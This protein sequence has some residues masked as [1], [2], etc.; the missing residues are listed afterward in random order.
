MAHSLS[1]HLLRLDGN[2]YKAYRQIKGTHT[3]NRFKLTISHVQADPF[4]AP[5][6]VS[7]KV[8]ADVA[9]LPAAWLRGQRQ[10]ALADYLNRQLYRQAQKLQ[11]DQGAG[12][13]GTLSVLQPSQAILPRSSVQVSEDGVEARLGVGLPAFGRRIA[14]QLAA[15][16]L[17]ET[18]PALVEASLLRTALAERE[19]ERHLDAYED[20]IA[21]RQ[22]LPEH[23]LVGFVANGAILPRRSG[24]EATPLTDGAMPFQSP[25][26]LEVTLQPPH[27]GAVTGMGIPEGVTLIVGGGYHGKSTLLRALAA[28]IYNHIPGDGREQVVCDATAVKIRAEEGRSV[29][30]VNISPFIGA[31][32]QGIST[33]AFS[34]TNASGSTSQATNIIEALE[35][36]ARVLLV[37]EDTAATNFMIRDRTMQALISKEKEPITPFVDK[38]RQLYN[39]YGVSTVLVMGGSGDYFGVADTVIALDNYRPED[40]TIAA[41][42]LAK[43][44]G[45]RQVEGGQRF[46]TLSQRQLRLPAFDSGRRSRPKV[47]V[48][49]V[50]SLEIDRQPIDLRAVAQLVEIG[51][52]RAIAAALVYSQQQGLDQQPLSDWLE[53]I[54]QQMAL[55]GLD[56]LDEWSRGDL[57]AFRPQELAAVINRVRTLHLG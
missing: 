57:T 2:S 45:P 13:S 31:L 8:P 28:G 53:A 1:N 16:L 51:Q 10:T 23:S 32:P 29:C 36:G 27:A 46:G 33:A 3:F 41:Q 14:G 47:K 26:S 9:G 35:A 37:D 20:A 15:K 42:A 30:G 50:D 55:E 22:Q 39:D 6:R 40:V 49:D 44:A 54:N 7:L 48:Y 43:A 19:V 34:T 52:L 17:C 24:I 25:A 38:V 12:K 5:S 18:I 11:S 21:L 4:A 56:S